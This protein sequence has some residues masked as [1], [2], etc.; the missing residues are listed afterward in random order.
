ME[1]AERL[2]VLVRHDLSFCPHCQQA[3]GYHYLARW[4]D[5]ESFAMSND[6]MR[7][8]AGEVVH[9]RCGVIAALI[10]EVGSDC[11]W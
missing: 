1:G 8:I 9:G 11:I 6:H 5:G 7:A 10:R 4:V 2:L 3:V